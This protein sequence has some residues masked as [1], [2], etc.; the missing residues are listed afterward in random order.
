MRELSLAQAEGIL[1]VSL[2]HARIRMLGDNLEN[3]LVNGSLKMYILTINLRKKYI[4]EGKNLGCQNKR[5]PPKY[6][7]NLKNLN[8]ESS[9]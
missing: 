4:F 2:E 3:L 7:P 8:Y 5:H 6:R 9:F 1:E